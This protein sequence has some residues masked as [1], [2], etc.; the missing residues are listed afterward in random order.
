MRGRDVEAFAAQRL[1]LEAAIARG[2]ERVHI[3]DQIRWRRDPRVSRRAAP[4]ESQLARAEQRRDHAR[5]GR[6]AA[7]FR[8]AD[9]AAD[10][11][12]RREAQDRLAERGDRAARV[13]RAE[14]LQR[15]LGRG[16]RR[17]RRGLE[18]AQLAERDAHAAQLQRDAREIRA[19]DLGHLERAPR[20]VIVLR[21]Q[22][23]DAAR[24]RAAGAARAL[25]AA[26]AADRLD[27]QLAEPRPR[28]VP[29]DAREAAVDHAGHAVDRH[30]GLGDVGREDHLAPPARRGPHRAILVLGGKIAVERD[31]VEPMHRRDVG[32]IFGA[33]ADLAGARQE[34][35]RISGRAILGPA[36]HG[37]RH[38]LAERAIVG[39]LFV[40]DRERECPA[41]GLHD[42]HVVARFAEILRDRLRR[43]RRRHRHEPQVRPPRAQPRDER[44]REIAVEVALVQLVDDHAADSA[45]FGIREQPARQDALGDEADARRGAGAAIEAHLVADLPAELDAALAGDARRREP[46]REPPRLQHD[47]LAAHQAGVEERTGNAR[48]LAGAGRRDQ[49]ARA[50]R[51]HRGHELRHDVVDREPRERHLVPRPRLGDRAAARS[52]A[53]CFV[54]VPRITPGSASSR[55][56]A[57]GA[58]RGAGAVAEP[59]SGH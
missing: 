11:R 44:E 57:L 56:L 17:R 26:R 59:R 2:D 1:G 25:R 27:A 30:R 24:L 12:M 46:C 3:V 50:A 10:A 34:H 6:D 53:D 47:D 13:D 45:Q 41:F 29:R 18:P 5:L 15:G 23:D 40:L 37:R 58:P 4:L 21:V 31:D 8:F 48:R 7:R 35:E 16:D 22:P 49:H 55:R 20:V 54:A 43:E 14:P 32:E 39:L 9:Q 36:P 42:R 33:T 28:R 19:Q 38:A 52:I 51:A